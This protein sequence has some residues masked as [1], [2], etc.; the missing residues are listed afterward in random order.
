MIPEKNPT[1]DFI[2]RLE[3]LSLSI[4]L[5]LTENFIRMLLATDGWKH[6]DWQSKW[7]CQRRGIPFL[8]LPHVQD[9]LRS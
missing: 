2:L 9:N 8:E 3:N 1:F 6:A 5:W 7:M 4:F